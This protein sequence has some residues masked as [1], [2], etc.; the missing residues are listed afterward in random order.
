MSRSAHDADRTGPNVV[1]ESAFRILL[2]LEAAKALRFGYSVSVACF[3]PDLP[4][5]LARARWIEETARRLSGRVRA[6]D[7]AAPLDDA[8]LGLL[9]V[10]ADTR[11]LDRILARVHEAGDEA[12]R[13]LRG[14]AW[15]VLVSAGAASYPE[16]T[17]SGR[18]LVAEARRLL[19][20]GGPAG[21][22]APGEPS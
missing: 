14:A 6:T 15:P 20:S 12:T 1:D 10:D 18:D 16:T 17:T 4:P 19:A 5:G 9:L 7:V 11:A 2:R 13:V 21:R 8:T 3:C 22:I